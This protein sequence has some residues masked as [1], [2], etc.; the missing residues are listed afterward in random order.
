M[1]I[2]IVLSV[3]CLISFPS[4]AA[5]SV[6]AEKKASPQVI[7]TCFPAKTALKNLLLNGFLMKV[8]FERDHFPVGIFVNG[9]G[10][11]IEVTLI[12]DAACLT[13]EGRAFH[14]VKEVGI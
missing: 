1:K 2:L 5:N 12:E 6:S 10:D 4:I 3:L 7:S 14:K 9:N 8:D 13:G 11:W